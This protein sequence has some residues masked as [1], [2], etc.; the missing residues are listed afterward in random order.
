MNEPSL[1]DQIEAAK[2]YDS[3]YLPAMFDQWATKVADAANIQSGQ[4]V[5]DVACGTGV[6]SR[7]VASRVTPSGY[8]AG[9]D[10][11][12]GML[13][14]GKELAPEID[15]KQ[16]VA[17]SLPFPDESFN[18][19]VCQFGLMFFSDH[20]ESS[21]AMSVPCRSPPPAIRFSVSPFVESS[22]SE[23]IFQRRLSEADTG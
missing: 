1:Q 16:G 9:L 10:P 4:R 6:L 13:A 12:P 21:I 18:T 22:H 17:E 5:L 3:L 2:V 23:L 8:I 14:V 11:S 20:T 15:W 7:E 19:V